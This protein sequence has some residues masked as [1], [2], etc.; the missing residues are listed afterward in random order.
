MYLRMYLRGAKIPTNAK[1]KETLCVSA[2]QKPSPLFTS[3]LTFAANAELA[4]NIS[5]PTTHPHLYS[6]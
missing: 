3:S 2:S 1:T 5:I 6:L 4:Y